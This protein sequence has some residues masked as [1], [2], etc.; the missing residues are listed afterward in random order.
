MSLKNDFLL[1]SGIPPD[2][3]ENKIISEDVINEK[4]DGGTNEIFPERVMENHDQ[5]YYDGQ[6]TRKRIIKWITKIKNF[7]RIIDSECR[8]QRSVAF[9]ILAR[10][11]KTFHNEVLLSEKGKSDPYWAYQGLL[12][13]QLQGS[14]SINDI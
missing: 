13:K 1:D 8:N 12:E 5:N 14:G 7:K 9:I 3:V 11:I 2:E 10:S 4:W 6:V